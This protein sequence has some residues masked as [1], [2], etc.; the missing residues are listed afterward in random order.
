MG[1]LPLRKFPTP[2]NIAINFLAARQAEHSA[3]ADE[4]MRNILKDNKSNRT[5]TSSM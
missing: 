4:I 3:K 1:C 5:A 2:G